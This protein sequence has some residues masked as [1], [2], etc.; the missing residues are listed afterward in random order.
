MG[1]ELRVIVHRQT[2]NIVKRKSSRVVVQPREQKRLIATPCTK[3]S[4]R[5]LR[6]DLLAGDLL[7]H[8][9]QAISLFAQ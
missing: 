3:D 1:I 4:V 9:A 6:V 5:V 8:A 7:I 2:R